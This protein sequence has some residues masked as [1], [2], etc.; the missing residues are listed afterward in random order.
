M[1]GAKIDIWAMIVKRFF[2][3]AR[4]ILEHRPGGG[5]FGRTV[6]RRQAYQAGELAP[7]FFLIKP[8]YRHFTPMQ[9][10]CRVKLLLGDQI[11]N[12]AVDK[13]ASTSWLRQAQP[14]HRGA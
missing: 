12:P 5:I 2:A 14:A 1:N 9:I 8:L 7:I 4:Q 11:T 3:F 6:N 10:Y 13:L